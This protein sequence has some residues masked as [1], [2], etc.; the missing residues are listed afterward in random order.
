MTAQEIKDELAR[1]VGLPK[2][3]D[4]GW[5]LGTEITNNCHCRRPFAPGQIERYERAFNRARELQEMI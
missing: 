5:K 3:Q 4:C 2:C 1:Y